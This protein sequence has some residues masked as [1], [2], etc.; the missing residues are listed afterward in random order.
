MRCEC[1]SLLVLYTYFKRNQRSGSVL[2]LLT[3]KRLQVLPD[4]TQGERNALADKKVEDKTER[5]VMS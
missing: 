3:V 5:K 2:S 4:I 1:T